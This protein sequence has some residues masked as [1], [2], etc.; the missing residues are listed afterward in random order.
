MISGVDYR[1]QISEH[2]QRCMVSAYLR[3]R[4]M[5]YLADRYGVA[6]AIVRKVLVHRGVRLRPAEPHRNRPTQ[7]EIEQRSA[8]V[9]A[10]WDEE[11]ENRRRASAYRRI[12]VE[13]QVLDH[14][15]TAANRTHR[16]VRS[17]R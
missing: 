4:S 2:S 3:G 16:S 15:D 7:E 17:S 1:D 11:T 14:P 12:R 13:A 6:G 10:T 5:R 8:E 9:R